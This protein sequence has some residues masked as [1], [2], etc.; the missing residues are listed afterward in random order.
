[1]LVY[2]KFY[3][4]IIKQVHQNSV[5]FVTIGIYQTIVLSF[6]QMSAGDAMIH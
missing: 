5:I 2:Y 6:N 1:M 4:L 3:L